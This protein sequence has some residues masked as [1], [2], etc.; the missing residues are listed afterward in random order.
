MKKTFQIPRL[1]QFISLGFLLFLVSCKGTK[2]NELAKPSIF[3]HKKME[4][5]QSTLLVQIAFP[6]DSIL[7]KLGYKA[8]KLVF[9]VKEGS[10]DPLLVTLRNAPKLTKKGNQLEISNGLLHIRTK[11]SIAGIQAGWI[12]GV[13]KLNV[14]LV[15]NQLDPTKLSF[16][17]GQFQY[18]WVEKPKVNVLGMGV[19]VSGLVDK[20]I[21]SN[22]DRI[23][24]VFL[25]KLNESVAPEQW[26]PLFKKQM[27]A[28]SF[29]MFVPLSNDVDFALQNIQFKESELAMQVKL[30]GL[31]GLKSAVGS[32]KLDVV[33][34]GKEDNLVYFFAE[35]KW[36]EQMLETSLKKEAGQGKQIKLSGISENGI[37]L[38]TKG[39]L[40]KK[41]EANF[42]VQLALN[43]S[44]VTYRVSD[45]QVTRLG[46]VY[47]LFKK[48]LPNKIEKRLN[49]Q[50]TN[51]QAML[52]NGLGDTYGQWVKIEG[53]RGNPDGLMLLARYKKALFEINP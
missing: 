51:V 33:M 2:P 53:I 9:E 35:S 32:P 42:Q 24:A 31:I 30:K 8:N 16:V 4:L 25:D 49:K 44:L 19:N 1:M 45:L 6:Y 37:G 3:F 29:G 21:Q 20:Y 18:Q 48:S 23:N 12:E 52:R 27:L 26:I 43:D 5:P 50:A 38:N 40:G 28:S 10:G 47:R 14:Q 13:L 15:L 46:L 11:P 39:F 34:K 36:V 41:S 22:Q 17:K 7:P